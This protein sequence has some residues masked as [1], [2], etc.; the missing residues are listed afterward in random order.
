MNLGTIFSEKE[1]E[2]GY[3]FANSNGYTIKEVEPRQEWQEK[4]IEIVNNEG[5]TEI[6]KEKELVLVRYFQIIEIHVYK[7][8]EEEQKENKQKSVRAVREQYFAD[9][10]DWYQSKPL[11]WEEMTEEEKQ[12]IANYRKYLMDYTKEEYWWEKNPLNFE[13][14]KNANLA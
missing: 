6:K 14:W 7:P 3:E 5:E 2:K 11:L 10:V 13:E 1:Y 8:T 12:D 4:E 9:Y